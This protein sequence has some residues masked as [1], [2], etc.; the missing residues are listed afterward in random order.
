MFVVDDP[1][2]IHQIAYRSSGS[3]APRDLTLEIHSVRYRSDRGY[4]PKFLAMG[5]LQGRET[6]DSN[7]L[8][9]ELA[10]DEIIALQELGVLPSFDMCLLCG[11]FFD[12]PDLR[13]LGGTGDVT[14]ALNALSFTASETFAVLGNHDE[15]DIHDLRPEI[16]LLDGD[17]ATTDTFTI[18]G[19]SGIIGS[20]RRNN[21]K[22]E[23]GFLSAL[24]RCS[25]ARTDLLLLHQGPQGPTEATR[26]L[27]CPGSP[28]IGVFVLLG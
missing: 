1:T 5:D 20:P 10:A 4:A 21:R 18:G 24:D 8:L 13:K 3:S 27:H 22:T 28:R 26:G 12:Y 23:T 14:P 7:R 11:D 25:N 6:G 2:L 19:V 17:V 16:T 9:G 15:V